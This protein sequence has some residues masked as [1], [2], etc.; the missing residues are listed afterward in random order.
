MSMMKAGI[1]A[2][3]GALVTLLLA[4]P[5][6]AGEIRSSVIAVK[7]GGEVQLSLQPGIHVTEGDEVRIEAEV[8]GVGVLAIQTLWQIVRIDPDQSMAV[9][10]PQG[11]L[12]GTPQVGYS[13][14]ITT[15]QQAAIIPPSDPDT[16]PYERITWDAQPCDLVG[17]SPDDPD[18]VEI[19]PGVEYL[20][21][22]A[23]A[24]IRDCLM[25]IETW[26]DTP[27]FYA[28]LTRGY[29]KNGQMENAYHAALT[30]ME[31]G[32][33][34]ATAFLAILYMTGNYVRE[35]QHQALLLFQQAAE[36]GNPGGMVYAASMYYQGQGTEP[37]A[38]AAAY[39]YQ[40]A[41]D[42]G[43]PEAY[44]NLG[45][46][47]DSG[48]GVPQDAEEA[49]ANLLIALALDNDLAKTTLLEEFSTLRL[50]TRIAIQMLLSDSG[51]YSGMVDGADDPATYRALLAHIM[52]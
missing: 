27:R 35:D 31:M 28:H 13:A 21:I 18:I 20:D 11:E 3:L 37:D 52:K 6:V 46:L 30:G 45:I 4:G 38:S 47:Y 51:N 23:D 41:A 25:A 48:Q 17:G 50:E 22:D 5:L 42:I 10:L 2:T 8:P 24:V 29:F 44:A 36:S 12:T 9:A 43:V 26:P 39:Y 1:A 33:G 40:M 15:T 34:Q 16:T 49:A 19:A 32:S 14:I 7:P